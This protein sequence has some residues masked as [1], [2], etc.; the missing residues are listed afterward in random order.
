MTSLP[1]IGPDSTR[2]RWWAEAEALGGTSGLLDCP[3][4]TDA[5]LDLTT[6]HPSGLAQLLAGGP[7]P[8]SS[9]VREAGAFAE[10]RRRAR[11]T[12]RVAAALLAQR[13]TRSL[14]VA[15]GTVG[16]S[17]AG[18]ASAADLAAEAAEGAAPALRPPR[19]TPVLLRRCTLTPS[20]EALDDFVVQL[21]PEVI[22]NPVLVRAA[23]HELG[24]DLDTRRIATAVGAHWGFDPDPAMQ[25][26]GRQLGGTTG[27]RVERRLVLATF[28]DPGADLLAELRRRG[29]LVRDHRV[30]AALAAGRPVPPPADPPG[31]PASPGPGGAA[32]DPADVGIAL[33]PAQRRAVEA[34]LVGGD[35][36]LHAPTGTGATQVAAAVI[37]GTVA[38]GRRVLLVADS[39]ADRR[40][41]D[42]RLRDHGFGRLVLHLM[43][44]LDLRATDAEAH[45][46]L[47]TARRELAGRA[48]GDAPSARPDVA[49]PA[50]VLEDH[51]RA[52]HRPRAPWGVSV[53]EAMEALTALAERDLPP[54]TTRRLRGDDLAACSRED[55]ERWAR[56]LVEAADLGAFE[57]GPATTPWAG[58][59]LRTDEAAAAALARVEALVEVRLPAVRALLATVCDAAGLRGASSV[60][61]AA[62]RTDLLVGVR[63]TT[64]RF[65]PEVFAQSLGDVAAATA[66][67]QWRREHE[68]RLGLLTRWRLRRSARTLLRPDVGTGDWATLHDWLQQARGQRLRWQRACVRDGVPSVPAD[69]DAL[70]AAVED[71]RHE[72]EALAEVLPPRSWEELGAPSLLEVQLPELTALLRRLAAGAPALDTLPRR[73][74]LLEQLGA[75]GWGGLLEDLEARW[76]GP[77]SLDL[78]SEVEAAW[79]AGVLDSVA[80]A[81]PL[82]GTGEAGT[83]RRARYELQ[84]AVAADRGVRAAVVRADLDAR[85]GAHPGDDGALLPVAALSAAGVAALADRVAEADLLVVLGAQATTTAALLP[86][87][88]RGRRVLVVGD[89]ALPG[90]HDLPT[91]AEGRDEPR[92]TA[93][94]LFADTEG[95]LPTLSLDRQ[96]ALLDDGLLQGVP[97][98][99]PGLREVSVPGP[100]LD[101]RSVA[102]TSTRP[103][104]ARRGPDALVDLV[105]ERALTALRAHPEE[106]LGIVVPDA[107]GA[108]LLADAVRRRALAQALPLAVGREPLLVATPAR[109]AGERRDHVLVVADAVLNGAS[110]GVAS[111]PPAG[112]AQVWAALTRSRLR[113]TLVLDDSGWSSGQGT[114]DP[115]GEARRALAVLARDWEE[116][117]GP[118]ARPGRSALVRSLAA[119]CRRLGLP[120]ECE[121]GTSRRLA[122]VVRDRRARAG[123]GPGLLVEVDDPAWAEVEVLDREVEGP[124]EFE[125]RG[126]R[127]VCVLESDVFA[128]VDAEAQRIARLWRD[129]LADTGHDLAWIVDVTEARDGEQ[130]GD[131]DGGRDGDLAGDL[132]GDLDAVRAVR[133]AS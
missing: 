101:G 97:Q 110:L 115:A 36:R 49:G 99:L 35:L 127:Y 64:A 27:L 9:L 67:P 19:R 15:V 83:L 56:T 89:P 62:E 120:V 12:H 93:G 48:G 38:A 13:G 3:V 5:V 23:H 40:A 88:S 16:W 7:A 51:A 129:A 113:T 92:S 106:S 6:A 75:A 21:A 45:R 30:V 22:V 126:W 98:D 10:A 85:A 130:D 128:D 78:P 41:V 124:T 63:A 82:V 132:T 43:A 4:G 68:V 28:A 57:V 66:T 73:T 39:A 34:V 96:H 26:L 94:S 72:L 76:T 70:V 44:D 60:A 1:A 24:V 29:A 103:P 2:R 112:R 122:L 25:E 118:A 117:P 65:G 111:D 133:D 84:L 87:L 119:A 18:P 107:A 42:E 59:Q 69:L 108:E 91:A 61:E 80:M 79:W 95:L 81:D 102:R 125:R 46:Q 131:V 33:D 58:A 31:V 32:A 71:L 90:P 54:T 11:T 52:M 123:V 37:A 105:A 109:W 114:D 47:D 121:V 20:S 53:H 50:R 14:A 74:V 8:L 116:H 77:G 55:V 17:L 100:G 104:G 86:A